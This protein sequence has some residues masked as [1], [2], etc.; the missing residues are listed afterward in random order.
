LKNTSPAFTTEKKPLRK[1]MHYIRAPFFALFA[2]YLFCSNAFG[3]I[4]LDQMMPQDI[5]QRTGV[6]TLSPAQKQE[7]EEWINQHFVL[8]AEPKTTKDVYLSQ[9][10]DQGRKL[11]L[12]DGSLYEVFPSDVPKTAFWITPFPLE[13]TPSGDPTYP[14]IIT[15]KTSGTKVKVKQLEPPTSP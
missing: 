13:I 15:N 9:N 12:T 10:L 1:T 6:S 4:A 5:Q 7:L 8:K 2:I 14:W 3:T 11:R